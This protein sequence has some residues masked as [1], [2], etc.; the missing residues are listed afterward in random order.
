MIHKPT[1][2]MRVAMGYTCACGRWF[3]DWN[4]FNV[5]L[6]EETND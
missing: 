1:K 4:E 3:H 6:T 2:G 5:H